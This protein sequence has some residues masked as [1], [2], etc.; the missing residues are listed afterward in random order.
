MMTLALIPEAAAGQ[1]REASRAVAWGIARNVLLEPT[2]YASGVISSRS[3]P[4]GLEE[5]AGALAHGWVEANPRFTISGRP[6]DNPVSYVAGRR[7]IRGTALSILRHSV[8]NNFAAGISARLLEMRYPSHKKLIRTLSWIERIGFASFVTY[9]NSA[10]HLR[11]AR[12]NRRLA[13]EYGYVAP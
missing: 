2:T 9:R 13:R 12:A 10:D 8:M 5:V 11:Q 1:A 4:L 3:D 7:I 6:N